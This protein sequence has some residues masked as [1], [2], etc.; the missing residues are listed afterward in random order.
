MRLNKVSFEGTNKWDLQLQQGHQ[1][2]VRL[3]I[4]LGKKIESLELKSESWLWERSGNICIEF[5]DRGKPTGIS[6]T[7]ADF[8]VH[9]LKRD[10]E[11]LV[12]LFFPI[13]RLKALA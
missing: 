9:E 3:A 13:E 4:A 5:R 12:Y 1:N 6:V 8:W 11:T 10:G 2:E 7:Q